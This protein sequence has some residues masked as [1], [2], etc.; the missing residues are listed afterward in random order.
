MLEI[1]EITPIPYLQVFFDIHDFFIRNFGFWPNITFL[2]VCM[3]L[4]VF[5]Y[6][7]VI[8]WITFCDL[9]NSRGSENAENSQKSVEN[10]TVF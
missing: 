5:F 9:H 10:S 4:D 2:E 1:T 7:F 6:F 3:T 8:F